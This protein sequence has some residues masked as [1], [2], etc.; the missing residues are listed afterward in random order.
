MGLHISSN[1]WS[2]RRRR[3]RHSA[4]A[5]RPRTRLTPPMFSLLDA[6]EASEPIRGSQAPTATWTD[7][8]TTTPPRSSRRADDAG[9]GSATR[10]RGHGVTATDRYFY[11][12]LT[13]PPPPP[14]S[15]S[16]AT[17]R[18][19]KPGTT[20]THA[21]RASFSRKIAGIQIG[22]VSLL[23]QFYNLAR[24]NLLPFFFYSPHLGSRHRHPPP[25]PSRRRRLPPPI[26][27][28]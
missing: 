5:H 25:L 1:T 13:S 9:A 6:R 21:H 15:G 18:G 2:P 8:G 22:T 12:F 16:V 20:C 28:R 24:S 26:T 3:R 11:P 4:P 17:T 19:G 23:P 14:G 27:T 10:R 7:L